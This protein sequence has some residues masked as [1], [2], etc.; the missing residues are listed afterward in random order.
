ME[1]S[2]LLI[3]FTAMFIIGICSSFDD[4]IKNNR[5]VKCYTCGRIYKKYIKCDTDRCD[6]I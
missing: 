2:N 1:F 5:K 4:Y 3:F 6:G